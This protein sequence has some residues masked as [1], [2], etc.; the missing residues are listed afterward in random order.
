MT[1]ERWKQISSL[2]HAATA[3]GER[4]LS[5]LL[6]ER[7]GS[8]DALRRDVEALLAQPASAAK[9]LNNPPS[10]GTGPTSGHVDGRALTGERLGVYQICSAPQSATIFSRCH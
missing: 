5:A 1:P 10:E 9:F 6:A 7:C 2:Y 3:C 4:E 8:D